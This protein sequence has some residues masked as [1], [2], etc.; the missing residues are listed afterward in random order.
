MYRSQNLF[1]SI[2]VK[3]HIDMLN[4]LNA[5]VLHELCA[6]S[7]VLIPLLK[8]YFKIYFKIQCQMSVV[9][10]IIITCYNCSKDDIYPFSMLC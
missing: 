6:C 8:L 7:G 3:V 5:E 2:Y 1:I 10:I 4:C 9:F